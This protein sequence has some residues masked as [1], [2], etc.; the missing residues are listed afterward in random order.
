M[1]HIVTILAIAS[2]VAFVTD[3]LAQ[4]TPALTVT[5]EGIG[6]DGY[7]EPEFAFCIPAATL[8]V[9]PG[10]DKSI[11]LYWSEGP[12]GTKSY[13]IIGVDTD[14]PTVFDDAGKEGKTLP[15]TMPRRNFYHWVLFDIPVGTHQIPAYTDSQAIVQHG[16]SV[17]KTPYGIRGVNDYAPYFASDPNRKGVYA[18][19][20][21]PCPPWNDAL[22][23]HYHFKVYA[24]DV[25]SLKLSGEV[26]GSKAEA[27]IQSHVLA[28]GEVIGKYT[29][30][31]KAAK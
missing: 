1:R 9:K 15:A 23:H 8:H 6:S 24:L 29:L 10:P 30:N 11:G 3:A 22:I 16:K 19:Y 13:A 27:A 28:V 2:I 12:E 4:N 31:P 20:D 25:K 26:T 18:G 14:V 7:I 17:L 5:A 21:G